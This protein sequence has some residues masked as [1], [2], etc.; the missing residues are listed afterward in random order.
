MVCE[1]SGLIIA[2]L[3]ERTVA[4][5]P[6]SPPQCLSLAVLTASDKRWGKKAWEG[7]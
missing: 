3:R 4:S 1:G 7:C 2:D 5:F 6:Q